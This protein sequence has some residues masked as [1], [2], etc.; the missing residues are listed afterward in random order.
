MSHRSAG[1]IINV[2][3]EFVQFSQI[4]PRSLYAFG[5]NKMKEKKAKEK[6]P[7]G[8][9]RY[10]WEATLEVWQFQIVTTFLLLIPVGLLNELVSTLVNSTHSALT[11]ANPG[12]LLTWRTPLI[13]LL[14]LAIVICYVVVEVFSQIYLC[15]DILTDSRGGV[16]REIIRGFKSVRRFASPGGFLMLFYVLVAVPICGVGFSISLTEDFYVPHFISSVIQNHPVTAVLYYAFLLLLILLSVQHAFSFHAVLIDGMKPAEALKYSRTLVKQHRKEFLILIIKT[17]VFTALVF[18]LVFIITDLVPS[19]W[20]EQTAEQIAAGAVLSEEEL[21]LYRTRC[22]LFLLVGNYIFYVTGILLASNIILRLTGAYLAYTDRKRE[23]HFARFSAKRYIMIVISFLL[24]L[25]GLALFSIFVGSNYDD[26]FPPKDPVPIVAHRT[27]G[28]MASE[29]SLE[30][31]DEAVKQGC[32]GSETDFQRT[33]EG[34]YIVNHDNTFKRLTGVDKKPSQMTLEEIAELRI[35]DTT[36]S[37][38]LLPVPTMEELL[39]RGKGR[40][41]LFLE[42]KGETADRQ[43]ADD[44][45]AAVKERDMVGDVIIISLKYDVLDYIEQVYPEIE[46]G[47]LIFTGIGDFSKMH[48]DMIIME[49]EMVSTLKINT[50]HNADKKIGVWTVNTEDALHDFLDM[51]VDAVITDEVL[52]AMETQNALQNRSDLE[53]MEDAFENIFDF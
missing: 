7:V 44:V 30:G 4:R 50:L 49:E 6:K 10:R 34:R 35:V 25:L 3:L 48:C 38:K 17:L 18:V 1:V 21:F 11:S 5:K 47:L 51:N 42:L 45:V 53:R 33:L 39:D 24:V 12:L 26:I 36:G 27:G 14:G 9:R 31:I 23:Q 37:G 40:I 8:I 19:L 22:A 13:L 15:H 28:F 16:F 43:M 52:L 2:K 46:T 20:L 32:Y 29:N 41:K